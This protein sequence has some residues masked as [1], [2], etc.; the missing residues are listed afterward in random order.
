MRSPRMLPLATRSAWTCA[1]GCWLSR[2]SGSAWGSWST[3]RPVDAHLEARFVLRLGVVSVLGGPGGRRRRPPAQRSG[4][5]RPPKRERRSCEMGGGPE[6]ETPIPLD[7]APGRNAVRRRRSPVLQRQS[8]P[9]P[10]TGWNVSA[11]IWTVRVAGL[12]STCAGRAGEASGTAR[13]RAAW[14][15]GGPAPAEVTRFRFT[16]S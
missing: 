11:S 14:P 15:V 2:S 3:S 12:G 13:R 5:R 16:P 6:V 1:R 9:A 4:W 8:S 10:G 7:D